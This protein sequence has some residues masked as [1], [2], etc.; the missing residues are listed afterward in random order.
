[1]SRTKYRFHGDWNY[2]LDPQQP[3]E[4]TPINSTPDRPSANTPHRLAPSS[5]ETVVT[6]SIF[7]DR[8]VQVADRR[9]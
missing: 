5:P 3:I 2:T 7:V 4:A 1:M 9:A 8:V 6:P